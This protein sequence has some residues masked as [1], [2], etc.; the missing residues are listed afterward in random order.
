M[1]NAPRYDTWYSS[2]VWNVNGP[3]TGDMP[4]TGRMPEEGA[5]L[6]QVNEQILAG[7]SDLEHA[8]LL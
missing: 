6:P 2:N 7:K 3:V 1:S 8:P 4:L 5:D